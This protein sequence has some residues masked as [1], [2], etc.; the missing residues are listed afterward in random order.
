MNL[1]NAL[2]SYCHGGCQAGGLKN[3]A[4]TP[5][6]L[7]ALQTSSK[8]DPRYHSGGPPHGEG[9]PQTGLVFTPR[10]F[11]REGGRGGGWHDAWMDSCLK[12]A[13]PIGLSPLAGGRAGGA[14][15]SIKA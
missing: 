2:V 11:A 1:C 13:V 7:T 5:Q 3:L 15:G 6:P 8:R 9:L 12:L 4:G 14:P 10:G